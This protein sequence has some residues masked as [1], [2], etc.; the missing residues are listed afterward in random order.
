[1]IG[2]GREG[3]QRREGIDATA[4][5]HTGHGRTI[6]LVDCTWVP[7]VTPQWP[8]HAMLCLDLPGV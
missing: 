2:E 1:M 5:K 8:L 3:G 7:S 6:E 4:N